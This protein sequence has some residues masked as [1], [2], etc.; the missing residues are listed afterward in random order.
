MRGR[1][2]R[3]DGRWDLE[4]IGSG[5]A[6]AGAVPRLERA[7]ARSRRLVVQAPPGS[8]KTTLVPPVVA[9]RAEVGAGRVVVMSPRRL[10]ARA[11]AARLAALTATPVG[12]VA[13]YTVRGDRALDAGAAIE[14]VTPGVLLRRLLRDPE[15]PGVAAVVLDE[16]HERALD[17]DLAMA[18]LTEVAQLRDDLTLVAM[19]AT[20]DSVRFAQALGGESAADVPIVVCEAEQHPLEVVWAPF[21]GART[22]ARGVAPAF[23]DHVVATTHE[24]VGAADGDVLVFVPGAWEVDR[25]VADVHRRLAGRAEVLPLHG[26]LSAAHQDAAIGVRADAGDTRPRVVVAT[27]VAESSLTVPGVRAVVDSGL[28]RE[29]RRD[30]ARGMSG[31]VTVAASRESAVQR[32]GR[33]ARLGPGRVVR[34]YDEDTYA[35]M[36]A[37]TTPQIATADLT[38]AALF[39]AAW[40][41]PGGEGLP[42]L[43]APPPASLAEAQRTLAQ[44][45]AV[46]DEGRITEHGRELVQL[47]VDPRHARALFAGAAAVGARTAAEVVAALADDSRSGEPDLALRLREW[48]GSGRRTPAATAW[49]REVE[50]LRRAVEQAGSGGSGVPGVSRR[51]ARGGSGPVVVAEPVGFVV[52]LAHP[53]RVGRRISPEADVYLLASGTRA[54]LPAQAGALRGAEWLAVAEVHRAQGRRAAGTGAVIRAAAALGEGDALAAAAHLI[55]EG[56]HASFVDGRVVARRVRALGAIALSSAPV[57]PTREQVRSAVREA[58]ERDGISTVNW[59]DAAESL[60]RR[61]HLLHSALGD[62]WPDVTDTGL[63]ARQDEWLEALLQGAGPRAAGLRFDAGVLRGLVP[64]PQAG[65]IDELAPETLPVASGSRIRLRYPPVAEFAGTVPRGPGGPGE[66]ERVVAAVKLQECFGMRESPLLADGRV[67]VQF[68]LLSPAG[69]PLAVTDDLASFWNGPYA[70]VR[71]EMRGRYPKHPW[72]EDPWSAPATRST[73]RRPGAGA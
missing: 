55:T 2:V 68:H 46:D 60:R 5:L 63:L 23:L 56:T 47:P 40:G 73:R 43:D 35:R 24:Q 65:R 61:L 50:R 44:L 34:C 57:N 41:A 64:W 12:R 1:L 30:R 13:G 59:S 7:L 21:G 27:S 42:L 3:M 72:P 37:A 10:T 4:R 52:A 39:L 62:P 15:L 11:G 69:R 32:A 14:F 45:G 20:L 6:F 29:P 18:M 49:R 19:S 70:Q 54:A 8:G 25:V 26:R 9:A 38:Q 16:V 58:L 67:R 71:A 33:A 66:P 31:L 53:D 51:A 36:R 28:A 17:S 48:A 22:D